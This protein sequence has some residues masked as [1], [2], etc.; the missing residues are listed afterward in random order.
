MKVLGG[1]LCEIFSIVGLGSYLG[2]R[3]LSVERFKVNIDEWVYIKLKCFNSVGDGKIYVLK[4][5]KYFWIIF[6]KGV[7]D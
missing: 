7:E 3:I 2:G 6:L 5:R 1:N 4:G